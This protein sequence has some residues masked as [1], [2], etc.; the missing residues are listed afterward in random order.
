MKSYCKGV[1]IDGDAIYSA[2]ERWKLTAA[3]RKNAWRVAVEHGGDAALVDEIAREIASRSLVLRPI[4]YT[5]RVERGKLRRIGVESVKQQVVAQ[6]VIEAVRPLYERRVGPYQCAGIK[7]RGQTYAARAT[8][9][10]ADAGDCRYYA[11]SDIRKC[12]PSADHG[13]VMRFYQ[14]YVRSDDVLYIVGRL[15]ANNEQGL[16]LGG[17]FSLVTM[18]LLLAGAYWHVESLGRRRRGKWVPY[19]RHQAWF[20]DDMVLYSDSK[21]DLRLA[22]AELERFLHEE[23]RL[24]LKGWKVCRVGAGE[25]VDLGGYPVRP[26]RTAIRGATFLAGRRAFR[27]F[28]RDPG[29]TRARRVG[30]YW[31]YLKN[32]DSYMVSRRMRAQESMAKA[33]AMLSAAERSKNGELHEQARTGGGHT[34]GRWPQRRLPTPV[35]NGAHDE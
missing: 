34:E 18:N 20:M 27:R 10:W 35:H 3:G 22:M 13:V 29:I 30:S 31:G 28:A 25:P 11:K 23:L 6:A 4:R 7:G 2:L 1:V 9:R 21:R 24:E 8:R 32:S 19:V 15:L 5:E 16:N 14:K 33:T 26:G 17:H 12:Y